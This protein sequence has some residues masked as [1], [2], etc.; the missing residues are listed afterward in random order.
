MRRRDARFSLDIK[1]PCLARAGTLYG[2][3]Y[4]GVWYGTVSR[5]RRPHPADSAQYNLA[6][7]QL[8]KRHGMKERS[9]DSAEYGDRKIM[10]IKW[11]DRQILSEVLTTMMIK[12]ILRNALETFKR[13]NAKTRE[14]SII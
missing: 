10:Q 6:E 7:G 2:L 5:E 13:K 12:R 3:H 14:K 8:S 9:G 1:I 4:V 11:D